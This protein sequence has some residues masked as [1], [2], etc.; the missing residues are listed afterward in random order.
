MATKW[1]HFL[2]NGFLVA[3]FGLVSLAMMGVTSTRADE[4][5][6]TIKIHVE[7]TCADQNNE[8]KVGAQFWISGS[9]FDVD[10]ELFLA[11][12]DGVNASDPIIIGPESVGSTG[13]F[14]AGPY[15]VA[16]DGHYKVY[17]GHEGPTILVNHEKT[18]VFKT[19]GA[20]TTTLPET[21]IPETTIP[22]TTIPETTVPDTTVPETTVPETTVPVTTVPIVTT[23]TEVDSGGPTSTTI[24]VVTTTTD[25]DSAGPTTTTSGA[26]P[27]TG[28]AS[29]TLLVLGLAL[30]SIGVTMRVLTRRVI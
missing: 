6:G 30:A 28:Q 8:P 9:G 4:T 2:T 7:A 10:I 5:H 22:E 20:V 13:S 11:V 19:E 25:V 15:T 29:D 12:T 23:T 27:T 3:G 1:R 14:C 16:A 21:T 24:P 17:V 26:L 18:K